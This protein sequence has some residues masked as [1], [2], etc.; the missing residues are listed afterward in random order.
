MSTRA[1]MLG[2]ALWA[3]G[4]AARAPVDSRRTALGEAGQSAAALYV[5]D[6]G[7]YPGSYI[8]HG[9]HYDCIWVDLAVRNDAFD[10]QVGIV[11]TGDGWQTSH[12]AFAGYEGALPDGRERWGLDVRD[13]VA[14]IAGRPRAEVEYAAFAT[15]NGVTSWSPYRNHYIYDRVTPAAPLR[16]LSSSAALDG[17][18]HARIRGVVRALNT[19]DARRVFVRYSADGWKTFAEAEARF[20]GPDFSFELP[21][22]G[23]PAAIEQVELALR[24][25]AGGEV[26]WDDDGGRSYAVRLAPRLVDP[27]YANAPAGPSGGIKTLVAHA[28]TALP[29][30][31]VT[32][33]F[34]DGRVVALPDRSAGDSDASG[35]TPDGELSAVVSSVGFSRGPHGVEIEVAAGPFVRRFAGPTLDVDDQIAPLGGAVV[36]AGETPWSFARQADGQLLV[37]TEQRILRYASLDAAPIAFAA[38]PVNLSVGDVAL[39][40]AGHVYALGSGALVRWNEDGTVD[41]GFG[42][43]G[44]LA[45]AAAWDGVPLCAAA[46]FAADAAG[47]YVLDSCNARVLRFSPAGAFVDALSVAS[48][49]ASTAYPLHATMHQGRLWVATSWYDDAARAS[50]LEIAVAPGAPM[51]VRASHALDFDVDAFA[52]ADD[53]YWVI[54]GLTDLE[55]L[56]AGGHVTAIWTGGGRL[57]LEPAGSLDLAK[58]VALEADGTIDV[59]S[60]DGAHL[61]RFRATPGAAAD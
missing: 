4:C 55:H 33:R 30:S 49:G 15:M 27:R 50:L 38:S 11:W 1:W 19:P 22:D 31:A 16:L 37:M 9:S 41:A 45:L 52:V 26:A 6:S 54:H 2:L 51:A 17:D 20:D 39:D 60:V 42:N 13:A 57:S 10:K 35:F 23:D 14:Q 18:G 58:H 25:E 36:G 48:A 47:I 7:W 21:I 12:T 28:E 44:V 32:L 46:D 61:E 43:A 29:V 8:Y 56:D 24:L 5:L 34:D 40:G 53:G 59:L 3:A